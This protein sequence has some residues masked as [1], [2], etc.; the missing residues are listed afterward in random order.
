MVPA[1][2]R[3]LLP[4]FAYSGISSPIIWGAEAAS[5]LR[6]SQNHLGSTL[7]ANAIM[8][9]TSPETTKRS[10]EAQPFLYKLQM[11]A[12]TAVDVLYGLP[13]S[14]GVGSLCNVGEAAVENLLH[15]L[16]IIRRDE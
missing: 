3:G 6:P 12:G 13:D 7:I 4:H 11:A 1:A 16:R 15:E 14:V 10:A 5:R 9:L 8:R 2:R